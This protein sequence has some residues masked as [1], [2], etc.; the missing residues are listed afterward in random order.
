MS[1]LKPELKRIIIAVQKGDGMVHSNLL[2][3]LFNPNHEIIL[4]FN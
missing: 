1:T 3:I 2:F 4:T